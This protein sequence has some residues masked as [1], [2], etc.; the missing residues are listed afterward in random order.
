MKSIHKELWFQAMTAGYDGPRE[1]KT[2]EYVMAPK[3]R[4]LVD[5]RGVFR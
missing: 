4:N 2:F 1:N 3:D 5:S